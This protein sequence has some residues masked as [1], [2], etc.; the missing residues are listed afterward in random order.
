MGNILLTNVE[1]NLTLLKKEFGESKDLISKNFF[2]GNFKA[3]VLYCIYKKLLYNMI[4]PLIFTPYYQTI[5]TRVLS[6]AQ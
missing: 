5:Y 6:D 2:I 3:I 1:K 4:E